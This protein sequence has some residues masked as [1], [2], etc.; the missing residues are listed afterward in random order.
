MPG[1]NKR[2][3]KKNVSSGM[4]AIRAATFTKGGGARHKPM[5][6]N[7]AH[8]DFMGAQE[9]DRWP[10]QIVADK[11]AELNRKKHVPSRGSKKPSTL[12]FPL[13]EQAMSHGLKD[14]TR[15]LIAASLK[16]KRVKR[17]PG[18]ILQRVYNLK[19]R[20]IEIL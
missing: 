6:A 10:E 9:R 13:M 3:R 12:G 7:Q 16:T 4:K 2:A 5:V 17:H 1:C 14:L 19:N 20:P 8:A 15:L 18:W 11:Y